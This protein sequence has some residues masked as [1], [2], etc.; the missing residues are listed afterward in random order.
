[1][2]RVRSE[3]SARR[4]EN[5]KNMV[6]N[7]LNDYRSRSIPEVSIPEVDN[8]EST[9]NLLD[10]ILESQTLWHS[11]NVEISSKKDGKLEI[12]L[13]EEPKKP[14]LSNTNHTSKEIPLFPNKNESS[15]S[16]GKSYANNTRY[17]NLAGGSSGGSNSFSMS[18]GSFNS[19]NPSTRPGFSNILG[20]SS[21]A[22][23][24]SPFRGT[25][26]IRWAKL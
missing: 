14:D 3:Y 13:K 21:S 16:D 20:N 12:K 1:M 15:S 5:R 25:A 7:I 26:P 2:A 23:D 18:T 17:S 4:I 8:T 22:L 10:S 24:L 11:K 9:S 19:L 6:S